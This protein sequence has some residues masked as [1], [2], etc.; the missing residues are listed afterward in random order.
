MARTKQIKK[1]KEEI[2]EIEEQKPKTYANFDKARNV[3]C[4]VYLKDWDKTYGELMEYLDDLHIPCACS[5]IHDKDTY[6]QADV[7]KWVKAHLDKNTGEIAEEALK[8]GIPA[9]GGQ[10]KEHVHVLL[11]A[12]G[13]MT[14]EWWEKKFEDFHHIGYWQQVN[15]VPSLL[16]YF[17]HMDS[18]EKHQYSCLEV[19]GFGGIDLSP[20]LKTSK[21]SNISTLLD[22]MDYMMQNKVKH[23]SQLVK[24]AI[25]TADMDTISCVTGRASFF[26]NYFK[27]ET[28]QRRER[29]LKEE[30]VKSDP[31]LQALIDKYM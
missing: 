31:A 6:T 17:A 8:A 29:M 19:H 9:V 12:H 13:P 4:N 21:V 23:Y 26:A 15:S 22:V 25:S 18:P 16:R 10:K 1:D 2:Q 20:L 14:V 27:S 28:D 11:C 7:N 30:M 3:T 5:P 24:W